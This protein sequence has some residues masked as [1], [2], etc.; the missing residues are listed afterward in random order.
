MGGANLVHI[1]NLRKKLIWGGAMQ[2]RKQVIMFARNVDR[3]LLKMN[4]IE[5]SQSAIKINK[6]FVYGT[7]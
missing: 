1:L 3:I 6:L 2:R 4:T 7:I 5:S